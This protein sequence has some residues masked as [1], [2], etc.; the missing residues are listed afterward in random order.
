MTCTRNLL[1]ALVLVIAAAACSSTDDPE[2]VRPL[3][4]SE[5]HFGKTYGEWSAEWWAWMY[6]ISGCDSPLADPTG[7]KCQLGQD[8]DEST[9]TEREVFFLAGNEGGHSDRR[10]CAVPSDKPLFFPVVNFKID[11][12]GADQE[13]SDADKRAAVEAARDS[14]DPTQLFVEIDGVSVTDLE[15]YW[16]GPTKF[17]YEVPPEPNK[18][19]CEG[20]SGVEGTVSGA[21]SGGYFVLL[22]PLGAG[23]HELRFGGRVEAAQFELDVTYEWTGK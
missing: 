7:L 11:D 9:D 17:D 14:I 2:V 3:D 19:S 6:G 4:P 10:R 20:T 21:Y 16:V 15:P 18:F 5:R 23:P 1:A 8:P 22:P 13:M 12:V